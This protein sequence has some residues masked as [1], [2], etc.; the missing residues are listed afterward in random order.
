MAP[1]FIVLVLTLILG[2]Y[3]IKYI[4]L[5]AVAAVLQ[6]LL[7]IGYKRKLYRLILVSRIILFVVT[8]IIY[9]IVLASPRW[10][11]EEKLMQIR[12]HLLP[13]PRLHPDD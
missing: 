2:A 13:K 8:I 11:I 6:I 10:A 3:E 4:V 9:I 1:T 5:H 12:E 7:T